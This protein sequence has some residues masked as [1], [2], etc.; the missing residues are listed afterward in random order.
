MC[1]EIII[2]GLISN[3]ELSYNDF[4]EDFIE[5]LHNGELVDNVEVYTDSSHEERMNEGTAEYII[6]NNE[7]VYLDSITLN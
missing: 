3:D 2:E 4:G 5:L 7:M 1:E 6:V